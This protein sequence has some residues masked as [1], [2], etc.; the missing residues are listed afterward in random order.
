MVGNKLITTRT[1]FHIF[2]LSL[3]L[4]A[5]ASRSSDPVV[6]KALAAECLDYGWERIVSA[7]V[8]GSL[9]SDQ[10]GPLTQLNT[11]LAAR[12]ARLYSLP[13]CSGHVLDNAIIGR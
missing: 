2:S 11:P 1:S 6:H 5:G 10:E 9:P 12:G 3:D 4:C 8:V 13:Y 7:S